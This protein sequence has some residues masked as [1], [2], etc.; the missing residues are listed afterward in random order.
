MAR[1]PRLGIPSIPQH[2][3]QRG[4]NR[5]A[6][7][8]ADDDHRFYL[9]C[10]GEATRKYRVSIHAYVLMTNHVH[11]LMTPTSATGISRVLQTLGRRYVRY[12]NQTY[13]RSGTLWE[14]WYHASLVQGERYLLTC[15]RYIELNPV[16]ARMTEDPSEYR[17]SSYHRNALGQSDKLIESH[18]NYL[19]LGS[20][21]AERQAAYRELF[22]A[23]IDP[24]MLKAI[25]QATQTNRVFGSELFQKQIEAAL[26]L[27]IQKH[28]PGP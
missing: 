11:V 9:E 18:A 23:H 10:L 24:G 15:H 25:R 4:N 8:Y 6:C 26:A 3:I 27:H 20:D 21:P 12:I 14:C 13:C 19:R 2:V 1:L 16:R 17:W 28:K 5:Q 22:R 7:F